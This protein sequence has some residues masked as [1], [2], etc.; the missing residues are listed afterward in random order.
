MKW[1]LPV[2]V[3]CLLSFPSSAQTPQ[4]PYIGVFFDDTHTSWCATQ[5]PPYTVNVWFWAQPGVTGIQ[6]ATFDIDFP[7]VEFQGDRVYHPNIDL[8][9]VACKKPCPSFSRGYKECQSDWV[10]LFHQTIL[11]TSSEPMTIEVYPFLASYSEVIVY[12][13]DNNELPAVVLSRGHLNHC[14]P[15]LV[16]ATTWGAIKSLY[17]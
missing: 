15:L 5:S 3:I 16:R 7:G 8:R 6:G 4:H 11:I 12:D 14:G 13:C 10:W 2:F 1:I 9:R 17:K